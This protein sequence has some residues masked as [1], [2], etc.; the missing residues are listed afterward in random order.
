MLELKYFP[1]DP[2][3]REKAKKVEDSEFGKK[4]DETLNDM[5]KLMV[6]KKGLGLA[7]NQAGFTKRFF[8]LD[9]KALKE[10]QV[11]HL[12]F[13]KDLLDEGRYLKIV[14]PEFIEKQGEMVSEEGCL[15]IPGVYKKVKRYSF[16]ILKGYTPYKEEFIIEAEG[17]VAKALQHEFD[18]LQG[19][20][21]IDYLSPLQKRMFLPKYLKN[22]SK[23]V[24]RKVT[25]LDVSRFESLKKK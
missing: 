11:G 2:V 5:I 10:R 14:N 25:F 3:L 24:G 16:V 13:D 4:L 18:H 8:V 12:K 7:A 6:E 23:I 21:F 17:I 20:L 22:L 15:S 9:M 19:T 1:V